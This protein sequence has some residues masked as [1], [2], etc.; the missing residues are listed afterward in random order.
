MRKQFIKWF[1]KPLETG[2]F[3]GCAVRIVAFLLFTWCVCSV[4]VYAGLKLMLY[5]IL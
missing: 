1:M 3:Y 5:L 4:I 2:D